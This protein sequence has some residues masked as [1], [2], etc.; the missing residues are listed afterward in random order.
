[1][2]E[3]VEIFYK[4]GFNSRTYYADTEKYSTILYDKIYPFAHFYTWK[5][6]LEQRQFINTL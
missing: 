6:T 4:Y 5:Q 1:M 2:L 3:V